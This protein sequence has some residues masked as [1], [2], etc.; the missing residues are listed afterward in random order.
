[1]VV[2]AKMV[3]E[4]KVKEQKKGGI[5]NKATNMMAK[6]TKS[7]KAEKGPVRNPDQLFLCDCNSDPD[8]N[9]IKSSSINCCIRTLGWLNRK[10]SPSSL[11][12]KM[13][14]KFKF[15]DFSK[16]PDTVSSVI[17]KDVVRTF[18]DSTPYSSEQSKNELQELLTTF[19]SYY[20]EIGYVQGMN[21][22]A[23]AIY[24]HC[25]MHLSLGVMM[26]LFESMELKDI[27]LPKLPGLGRHFQT[28]DMLILIH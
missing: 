17:K 19:I 6:W 13:L 1:M 11:E 21:F 18:T 5:W 14:E 16:L 12:E 25:S 9:L 26:V 24:Y 15:A 8:F 7:S 2:A 20:Q 4:K 23:A 10:Y 22:I 3:K 27:F 28:I